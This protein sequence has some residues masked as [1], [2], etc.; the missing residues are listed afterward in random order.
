MVFQLCH[1]SER[2]ALAFG[3]ISTPPSAL[4]SF[5]ITK[6]WWV[7]VDCHSSTKFIS[8]LFGRAMIN[9]QVCPSHLNDFE[10]CKFVLARIIDD[11]SSQIFQ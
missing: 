11:A 8:E 1:R 2:L 9:S 6:Q 7:C 10:D 3:F 4:D 5:C